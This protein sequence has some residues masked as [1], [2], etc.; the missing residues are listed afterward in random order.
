MQKVRNWIFRPSRRHA[1]RRDA[2]LLLATQRNDYL[3]EG[4]KMQK[5][6]NWIVPPSHRIAPHRRATQLNATSNFP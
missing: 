3:S 6:R 5:V 2:T 4:R 1:T